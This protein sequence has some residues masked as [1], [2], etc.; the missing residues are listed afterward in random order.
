MTVIELAIILFVIAAIVAAVMLLAQFGVLP[1]I[2]GVILTWT[3]LRLVL[4]F[5]SGV[6][7]LLVALKLSFSRREEV[8]V[9]FLESV[10]LVGIHLLLAKPWGWKVIVPVDAMVLLRG[11]ELTG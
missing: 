10:T 2:T 11:S 7:V 1:I 8:P 4:G 9:P 6:A 3:A 5:L